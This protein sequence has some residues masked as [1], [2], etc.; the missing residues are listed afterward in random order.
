MTTDPIR[1]SHSL[2]PVSAEQVRVPPP[3]PTGF[4]QT[5]TAWDSIP[6]FIRFTVWVYAIFTVL[7]LVIW[8]I[9]LLAVLAL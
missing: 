4:V 6:K 9:L 8:P 2:D 7:G 3:L 5:T 1:Y